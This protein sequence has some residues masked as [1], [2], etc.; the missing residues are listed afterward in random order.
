M[1]PFC[2]FAYAPEELRMRRILLLCALA[3]FL[4]SLMPLNAEAGLFR[5]KRT[6][7]EAAESASASH[8]KKAR[9]AKKSKAPKARK[10]PKAK[11]PKRSHRAPKA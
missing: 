4:G 7:P 6:A 9:K 8:T 10:A 11:S 1:L 2:P 5:S 3:V